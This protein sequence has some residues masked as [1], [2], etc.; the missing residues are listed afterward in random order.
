MHIAMAQ[1]GVGLSTL[2]AIL[3]HGSIRMVEK[4]VRPTAE[5]KQQAMQRFEQGKLAVKSQRR[6]L[7]EGW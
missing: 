4:C 1:A 6:E 7:R 3:G 2:A 5:H